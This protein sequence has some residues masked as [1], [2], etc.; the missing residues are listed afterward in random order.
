MNSSENWRAAATRTGPEWMPYTIGLTKASWDRF[1]E[2]QE[3]VVLNH[4]KTWP[5][6]Q[7]GTYRRIQ[8]QPWSIKE[9]P[10]RDFV[11]DWGCVWR[12]T[13]YGFVGTIV[14][15][16]LASDEALREFVAPPAETYNGGQTAADFTRA[17]AHFARVKEQGGIARGGLDHGFFML[18]LEYLRGFENLM[19]DLIQPTDEFR[20]LHK[21]VH[22][23][24]L[25]AV[26]NWLASGADVVGLPEDLGGQ[27]RSLIGPKYFREWALPCYVE[28][29]RLAQDSGALTYFHCDGNIMDIAD[30]ILE[31]SP[32][33]FN[34]QDIAN[35]VENLRDTFRGKLTL[36]LDFDRQFALPFGSPK[37]IRELIEYEIRT[38]GSAEGGLM[39]K[40]EIRGDVPPDNLDAV[41]SA[42]ETYCTFWHQ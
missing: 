24:N 37:D 17:A 38:L 39:V 22:E 15:H 33:V 35:G 18:R 12:T 31:I 9:D 13:Q 1:G 11:D 8:E 4:P 29:H 23:L 20:R 3:K 25:A 5:N 30:Q 14:E 36:D 26:R 21:T 6:W 19:C 27:D 28:L 10:T 34:P 16:P 42:L 2:E 32:T 40:V 7:P 41:V